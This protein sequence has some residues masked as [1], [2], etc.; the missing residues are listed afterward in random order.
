MADRYDLAIIGA[1]A[2]GLIAADFAVRLG[3]RT[4][5]IEKDRLGGD[6]TW[7]GC[8]PSKTLVKIARVAHQIRIASRYGIAVAEPAIDMAQVRDYVQ[9]A[10]R[11]IYQG[12]TP[13]ALRA[14]GMDVYLGGARFLDAFT[15]AAG[16]KILHS[17]HFLIATGAT[18]SVPEIAA[19]SAVP[20]VTY[21]Q[22]F[23]NARIPKSL[24]I[25]GGGPVG[26][27]I[28]QAYQ[29]LGA[30]VTIIA[31]TLLPKEDS[32]V[33][34]VVE[35]V[36]AEEGIQ[37]LKARA[38]A[39]RQDGKSIVLSAGEQQVRGD[40]LLIAAGRGPNVNGLELENARVKYSEKGIEVDDQLRTS[41]PHIYAAGDVVGSYQFS[42]YAGWQAFQAV[43]NALLP[44]SGS[45]QSHAV[46]WITFIDPEVARVGLGEDQARSRF[47]HDIR[48][49]RWPI[50][51]IDRAVCEDDRNGF[52]K[53]IAKADGSIV[54]A[55]IVAERAG[56]AITEIVLAIAHA[57]K[58]NDIA[59]AIHP[60]PTYN[61]AVQLVT[62]QMAIERRLS[63]TSGKII[64]RLAAIGR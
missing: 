9:G 51:K 18:P 29:R 43:R 48:V 36:F 27:E 54:G 52:V 16:D 30:Q 24:L 15:I 21:Q 26:V 47:G 46:P 44:G 59:G 12:T 8:I 3:A 19:L 50:E 1:G 20:Y 25:V 7:T 33:R 14:K 37:R 31:N 2:A 60:Y 13:E 45:G 6:C 4:A 39:V 61:S 5:L 22:I 40:L 34:E 41:A 38:T 62:T 55:S 42:H 10:V 57:L 28:A 17:R 35:R 64:R 56:E 58:V 11:Q 53:I 49:H 32:D 63:G 23:E